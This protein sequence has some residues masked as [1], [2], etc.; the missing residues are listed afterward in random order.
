MLQDIRDSLD[1]WVVWIIVGI[2]VVPFAF[3]GI[4]S[5]R[6]GGGDPVV[7]KVGSQK[8]TQSEFRNG[9]EQRYQQLV[10]MMGDKF[11]PDMIDQNRFRASV[12]ADMTQEAMQQQYVRKLGYYAGDTELYDYISAIPAFQENGKFSNEAYKTA[13][14]RRG[15]APENFE[16]QLRNSM[17]IDQLRDAVTD[18]AFV[19]EDAVAQAYRLDNEQRGLMY[20]IFDYKKYLPGITVTDEQVKAHYDSNKQQYMAPERVKLAYLEL[21]MDDMSKAAAPQQD[22]L[23][24]IYDTDKDSM[25]TT[26]EQRKAQHILV[27]FGADKAAAKAK[28]E[29]IAAQLKKGADFSELAKKDSDDTGSKMKGGDLGWVQRGQ[30]VAPFDKALFALKDGQTSDPVETQF[31]WHIIHVEAIRPRATKPFDD[32]EVQKQLINIYQQKELQKRFQ[33]QSEKLEQLVFENPASL[34]VAAKALNLKVQTTDWMTRQGGTGIAAN[35]SVQQVAFSKETITNGDNSKPISLSPGHVVVVRKADYEAAR[36]KTLSEVS[37]TI[38]ESLKNDAAKSKAMQEAQQMATAVGAGTSSFK[39]LAA[40]RGVTLKN[41]GLVR[42]DDSTQDKQIIAALF[43]L[44]RPAKDGDVTASSTQ[45]TDGDAAVVALTA[46]QTP[47]WPPKDKDEIAKAQ[48]IG[49]QLREMSAGAAF[50]G[51]RKTM[52]DQIKVK[53]INAPIADNPNPDD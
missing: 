12:L 43:R 33:E 48:Q 37:D 17:E 10:S 32:P 26:P 8:I 1:G 35:T 53:V 11:R 51:Y 44:P 19:T 16:A 29:A 46:V 39:D 5:F 2:I 15:L 31:G 24:V 4:E 18:T 25:F 3:W 36:Q 23:K 14:S 20:A 22:V 6:T 52:A 21:S 28:I 27:A 13:L 40:A 50:A 34:D 45:L 42:R 41:V 47:V 49:S 30:M 7:A 38:R 9:Y